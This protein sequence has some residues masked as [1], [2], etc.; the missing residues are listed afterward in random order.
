[1]KKFFA[2][3]CFRLAVLA[4]VAMSGMPAEAQL[5]R[6]SYFMD[7]SH[8][9]MQLNPAMAPARGFVHLPV[10]SNTGAAYR[11]S[12]LS[13]DNLFD[14]IDNSTHASYFTGDKFYNNLEDMNNAL[15]NVGTDLLAV[16]WWHGQSFW[17][18]NVGLKVD[19][20]ISAPRALFSFLRDM[21]GITGVDYANYTSEVTNEEINLNA[22]TEFGVGWARQYGNFSA[23]L[24]AK[25]LMGLGNVNFKVNQMLVKTNFQGVDP[26]IDWGEVDYEDLADVTG[27]ATVD[28]D[29]VLETSFEGLKYPTNEKGYIDDV[30]FESGKMGAAGVGAAFDAGV[31]WRVAGGLTLSAAVVDLGFIKW[32]KKA[33]QTAR[34]SSTSM[35]FSTDNPEGLADFA[36]IVSLGK[37][38][39]ADLLRLYPEGKV[40]KARTT[41]LAS[42]MVVGAEYAFMEDRLRLGALYS[43]HF[44]YVKNESEVTLSVNYSPSSL[45]DL[46]VS[47]SPMLSGGKSFG[48]AV[49]AGPL[50]VG[51]DY[52]YLGKDTKCCNA[53]VGLSIPLGKKNAA[54]QENSTK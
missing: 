7:G 49:K 13:I 43:N 20:D 2:Y 37:V 38:V 44:A 10:V 19:G 54:E 36:D 33:S 21:K 53:L 46:A 9:R 52:M 47:Y 22:Y 48:I 27:T 40:E 50:F 34:S 51:T 23:G 8:Y 17:S 1:M 29:A 41:N 15:L 26:Y 39:N 45:V 35:T 16:G 5:L 14:I 28:V 31:A 6:T 3:A 24:R 32:S 11:S 30:D 25:A 4:V 42:T 12:S 18:L